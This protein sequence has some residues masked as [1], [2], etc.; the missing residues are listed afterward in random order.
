MNSMFLSPSSRFITQ[1]ENSQTVFLTLNQ[2]KQIATREAVLAHSADIG[3]AWDGDFDR[4]FFF[5]EQG[6]YIEGYYIVGLLTEA[7]L[8]KEP[9]ATV[10]H[11]MR[12]TWNTIEVMKNS[13]E[14]LLASSW[15]CPHQRENARPER[16]VRW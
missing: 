2:K 15:T 10:L 16:S 1:A 14:T 8:L 6:N 12:M 9:N 5:D 13:V 7:F 3:I 11:D 4:C